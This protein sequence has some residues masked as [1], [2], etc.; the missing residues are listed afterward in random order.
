MPIDFLC[1]VE[2]S[3]NEGTSGEPDEYSDMG[4]EFFDIRLVFSINN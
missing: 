1:D 3:E 4:G 2:E